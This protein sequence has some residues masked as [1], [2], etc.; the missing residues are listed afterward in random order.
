MTAITSAARP[1]C[2][3]NPSFLEL[4]IETTMKCLLI[5]MTLASLYAM[6]L[7]S[8]ATALLAQLYAA[9]LPV[10]LDPPTR[11]VHR[12]WA[13]HSRAKAANA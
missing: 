13:R 4:R 12:A 1:K 8:V 9:S 2:Q 5:S 10:W 3:N 7:H 11:Q 6:T